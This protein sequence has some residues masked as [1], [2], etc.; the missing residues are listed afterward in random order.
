MEGAPTILLIRHGETAWNAEGKFRGRQD[1]DLNARG[2]RQAAALARGLSR[3]FAISHV[4][5]SPLRRCLAAAR[6]LARAF[7]L[8]VVVEPAL[9][10]LCFGQ[11]EGMSIEEA[12]RRSPHEYTARLRGDPSF[13]PPGGESAVDAAFRLQTFVDHVCEIATSLF[14]GTSLGGLTRVR[15]DPA[16]VSIIAW[17]GAAFRAGRSDP[18]L[19]L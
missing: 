6:P 19:S 13:R 16:A 5:S 4:Y 7:G 10:D 17:D 8:S 18:S 14:L 2:G 9:K 1:I 3:T 11:W 15:H 12:A